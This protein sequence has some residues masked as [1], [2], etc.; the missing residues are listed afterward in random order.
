MGCQADVKMWLQKNGLKYN[1]F[2]GLNC[3]YCE[4]IDKLGFTEVYKLIKK[5]LN[6]RIRLL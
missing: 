2:K 4:I 5:S 1:K 6:L 3:T